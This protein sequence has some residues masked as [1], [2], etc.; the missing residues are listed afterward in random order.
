M[1]FIKSKFSR[2]DLA[3]VK[4]ASELAEESEADRIA[5]GVASVMAVIVTFI[6]AMWFVY[7]EFRKGTFNTEEICAGCMAI[8]LCGGLLVLVNYKNRFFLARPFLRDIK[9]KRCYSK[10][11]CNYCEVVSMSEVIDGFLKKGGYLEVHE[12]EEGYTVEAFT[13]SDTAKFVITGEKKDVI[14]NGVVNMSAY[15]EAISKMLQEI[16]NEIEG[17]LK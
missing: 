3:E 9:Y 5:T 13:G 12:T 8:L 10:E 1:R 17:E 7:Y 4:A 16:T 14:K 2:D 11:F 6:V 15:D